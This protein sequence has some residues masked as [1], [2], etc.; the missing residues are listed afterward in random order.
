V[1]QLGLGLVRMERRRHRMA[2]LFETASATD[3]LTA[4]EVGG[5]R[6]R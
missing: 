2:E 5:A 3:Q 6:P 1:V 4:E